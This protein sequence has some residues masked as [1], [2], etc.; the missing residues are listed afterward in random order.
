MAVLQQ[1]ATNVE[2]Q[3]SQLELLG[4]EQAR[5]GSQL[6]LLGA[7]QARQGSQLELLGAEQARQ[8]AQLELLGAEQARQ[9]AQLEQQG[10]EQT[11]QGA[12]LAKLAQMKPLLNSI[13]RDV[14]S[15]AET[16]VRVA[17]VLASSS[18]YPA[19]R[20]LRTG[21]AGHTGIASGLGEGW[22]LGLHFGRAFLFSVALHSAAAACS[23][24]SAHAGLG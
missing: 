14:G 24:S 22:L 19:H 13:N 8:G 18:T 9:G 15:V 23:S 21:G 7:E 4:A 6:E 1:L 20:A 10:A 5:Q 16:A 12:Q 17:S 11:R 3:G 2:R